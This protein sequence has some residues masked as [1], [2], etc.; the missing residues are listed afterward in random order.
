MTVLFVFCL[1]LLFF[2]VVGASYWQYDAFTVLIITLLIVL[3]TS[4]IEIFYLKKKIHFDRL[5][6]NR[7]IMRGEKGVFSIDVSLL[8]RWLP[9]SIR[10]TA[11][12]GKS[13]K[14]VDEESLYLAHDLRPAEIA[15][16]IF[17]VTGRHCGHL[18]LDDLTAEVKGM[19]GIF[20][21]KT[22][23]LDLQ[24]NL[25]IL[26]LPK[27]QDTQK[28]SVLAFRHIVDNE[29]Q[30]RRVH[31]RSDE[32][33][34]MRNY[35]VGDELRSI[36]WPIS[37]RMGILVTK[38]YE[39]PVS[40][41]THL[42][43]DDFTGYSLSTTREAAEAALQLRD[44]MLDAIASEID[45]LLLSD[46]ALE[47]HLG[48]QQTARERQNIARE[49]LHYRRLLASIEA[50]SLPT[51]VGS[52]GAHRQFNAD[53]RCML[54]A[55]RLSE[56]SAAAIVQLAREIAEV[57]FYYFEPAEITREEDFALWMIKQSPV[58]L[59]RMTPDRKGS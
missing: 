5:T 40:I 58:T 29:K 14:S 52:I 50:D 32:I 1:F 53:D 17:S 38:E 34:T 44:T 31:E 10:F 8:S 27:V 51:L 41:R 7:E 57:I 18:M 37:S 33:D 42:L 25:E 56:A 24:E 28:E 13:D 21:Y 30:R 3:V 15:E 6:A 23:L 54:F 43:L 46:M 55:T 47:L 45:K 9:A 16:F 20:K 4:L 26:V 19:L 59:I 36:H 39:S 12:Y 11:R 22:K 49:S 48:I 2:L 35:R